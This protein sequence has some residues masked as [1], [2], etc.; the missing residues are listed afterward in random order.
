ME[1]PPPKRQKL[2]SASTSDSHSI[3]TPQSRARTIM[4]DSGFQ[5]DREVEVGITQVVNASNQGFQ[6]TLKQRYTDFQVNEITPDGKVV[7]LT[8]DSIPKTEKGPKQVNGENLSEKK[9]EE[10]NTSFGS[11]KE[12]STAPDLAPTKISETEEGS[13]HDSFL[14]TQPIKTENKDP[15]KDKQDESSKFASDK[16]LEKAES[17]VIPFTITTADEELLIT[18]FGVEFKGE[19]LEFHQKILAKP[20]AKP[21]VFGSINTPPITDRV[22]RGRMH[23]DVRRIFS[24]RLET[25]VQ[26]EGIIRV[27]AA[28]PIKEHPGGY[29]KNNFQSQRRAQPQNKGKL[30]WQELGGE[31]L[32]F[33]LY[34]EN[35]DTMEVISFLASRMKINAKDFAFAGTKDR[36][37]VTVQRVSLRR[38]HADRVARLNKDLRQARV[39]DFKYE[40]HQLELGELV[41]NEF[42]I[43]LRDCHFGPESIDGA[44]LDN[45]S[46]LKVGNEVVGAAVKH[47]KAHGFINYYGLQRFGTFGVGTDE[48]GKK[49]LQGDFEGAVNAILAYNK[50][51]LVSDSSDKI[52]RDDRARI[53]AI[54]LFRSSKPHDAASL[55][56]RKFS[57]EKAI[58]SHLG[59]TKTDYVGALLSINR[60]LRLMYV[61]AYQSLV[62]NAVSSE[63][64]A[65][66]GAKVIEGDL[67]IV[68]KIAERAV[69]TTQ[70]VDEAGEVII[71]PAVDDF[72]VTHDDLYERARPLTAEEAASGKY[73]VFDIVLPTPGYDIEYPS[74]DIGDFYKEFMGSVQ[75]GGLDPGNMRRPQKDFSLSGSYRKLIGQIGD[76]LSFEV[77]KY[78]DENEQLVETDLEKLNKGWLNRDGAKQRNG[79]EDNS[80]SSDGGRENCGGRF[81]KRGGPGTAAGEIYRDIR[82]KDEIHKSTAETPINP[83]LLAWQNLPEKLASEEKAER[84]AA[85]LARLTVDP[86][87]SNGIS[88]PIVNETFIETSVDDNGKRT[89][90]RVTKI[91]DATVSEASSEE[92]AYHGARTRDNSS[93]EKASSEEFAT[94]SGSNEYFT[95]NTANTIPQTGGEKRISLNPAAAPFEP[96]GSNQ[97]D[98]D[99]VRSAD[100]SDDDDNGGVEL[101]LSTLL[102][103]NEKRSVGETSLSTGQH[104]VFV[105]S[106]KIGGGIP[107]ASKSEVIE[108]V[109]MTSD[110]KPFGESKEAIEENPAKI[111]VILKFQLGTS[112][113]ATMALR[114]LMG[115]TGV[116]TYKPD[117]SGGR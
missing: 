57:G 81:N 54:R 63:R 85:E 34:K 40:K 59:R 82:T 24:S 62:W 31:Y 15:K 111:A 33:S 73:S 58:I 83:A 113:Y 9:P 37:A 42:V 108:D 51:P 80:Y 56:P 49:I 2:E 102:Y 110:D 26:D 61:H 69:D 79:H 107:V 109:V 32:H 6:G 10:N 87:G 11:K 78:Y 22:T 70:E 28:P 75:G 52:S 29:G 38:Q 65:R 99:Y 101:R 23:G 117:F 19:L 103:A 68:D 96:Q 25:E 97:I 45:E 1:P 21:S 48:V 91:N 3:T 13:A 114:E 14:P 60:G 27:S 43:T 89:R 93:W 94:A 100:C 98:I 53:E 115:L 116:K 84:E 104:E 76:D 47:L 67:I 77:K 66:Y 92:N 46:R 16:A 18:Y 36:R 72:A 44:E 17:K 50:E 35:K 95:T 12:S 20:G 90:Q 7:H 112:Q 8:D 86:V 64:W 39:G 105:D 55:L 4:S 106:A 71:R 41:G 5:P 74:N 30:G 88:Q